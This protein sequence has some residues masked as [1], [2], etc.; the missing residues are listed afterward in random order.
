MFTEFLASGDL[1]V[2]PIFA[3]GIFLS[4]FAGVVVW[5]SLGLRRGASLDRIASMPLD[6]EGAPPDGA[7]RRE[8]D[9]DDGS[10]NAAGG[11]R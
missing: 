4:V 9:H 10:A 3:M 6:E 5:V 7:R 8:G 1:L 11:A 2:L